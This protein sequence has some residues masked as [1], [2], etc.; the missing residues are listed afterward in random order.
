[1]GP[2]LAGLAVLGAAMAGC[3]P[4]HGGVSPSPAV[5]RTHTPSPTVAPA[6]LVVVLDH[7][8]GS[9]PNTLRLIRPDGVQVV[10]APLD[11][12]AESV[13]VSGDRLLVA[14]SG[15]LQELGRDGRYA[16]VS[17]LPGDPQ[18][19]L[20]RGLVGDGTGRHWLWSMVG[21]SADGSTDTRLYRGGPGASPQL[22]LQRHENGS[23]LQPVAWTAGGPVVSDEPLGIGG[24]VL[25][26]RAFGAAARL[27]VDSGTV[28]PLTAQDCAFSDLA[29]DGTV[30]CILNGREGP[31]GNGPVTLRLQRAPGAT[32]LDVPLPSSVAQAGAAYF[33]PGGDVLTL[34]T[35]PA[36]GEG[37][38]QIQAE[39]VDVATGA[40]HPFGPGG[41]MPVAWMPDG[42]LLA[43][44]LPGVAGGDAGTYLVNP[45]GNAALVSTASTVIGVLR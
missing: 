22:V 11:P 36:L 24:Y 34:A 40:H 41:L 39:L 5:E 26:R 13:A 45:D 28:T 20:V 2:R 10:A 35:S 38:E 1:M 6:S 25:F 3:A 16:Q 18:N 21:T 9:A 8:F 23:A 33:R 4:P 30:A 14:G 17:G 29:A 44:R 7:P 27:G 12:D 31:H 15:R 32:P 43:V 42:T 37:A 19:D